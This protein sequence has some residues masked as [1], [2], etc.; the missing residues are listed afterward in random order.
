MTSRRRSQVSSASALMVEDHIRQSIQSYALKPGEQIPPE[1]DLAKQMGVS[2]TTV[3]AGLQA[4]ASKGVLV[5]KH[6]S[7]T[8]VAEGPLVLDSKHFHF[9]SAM[10]GYSRAEM[11]QARRVLEGGAAAL[12]AEEAAGND[13]AAISDAVTGMF[14]SNLD[15]LAFLAYDAQFHRAVAAASHNPILAS[16]V[17][18]VAGTFFEACRSTVLEGRELHAM[19]EI[20]RLI[21]QAIR[22][23]D[24]GLAR[25][26]MIQHLLDAE[27]LQE[28]H[29]G[30]GTAASAGVP[31]RGDT[32]DMTQPPHARP[33]PS[34]ES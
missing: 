23:R 13:L 27:R 16:I 30:S 31:P 20:H 21:Y 15:S 5:I 32:A 28:W 17:E 19:A 34:Q 6:G 26:R 29:G 24:G 1:R 3:R 10:H 2:R 4:L 9:L 22:S 33:E 8:F 11:F 12:A 7:G 14:A 18:M 25:T